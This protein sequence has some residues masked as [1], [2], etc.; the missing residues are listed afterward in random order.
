MESLLAFPLLAAETT[1]ADGGLVGHIIALVALTAME[2]VLGIDNIVFI[3]VI[4]ARLPPEQQPWARRIGLAA[5]MIMRIVLLLAIT[6]IMTLT[7]P[8]FHLSIAGIS[9]D[10]LH[11]HEEINVVSWK[12]LILLVGG[13]F[14]IRSAV[15]EI[16][17]LARVRENR[18]CVARDEIL[19]LADVAPGDIDE[20]G[21]PAFTHDKGGTRLFHRALALAAAPA[22]CAAAQG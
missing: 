2:I 18:R 9:A 20:D 15:V 22:V 8:A 1:P 6:W 13:L 3:S 10:W 17:N 12:D 11:E 19:A 5:A 7:Q 16:H 14:L 21:E 4:T